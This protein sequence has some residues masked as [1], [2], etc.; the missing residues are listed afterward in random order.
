MYFMDEAIQGQAAATT[1]DRVEQGIDQSASAV[2]E[3]ACGS[4]AAPITRSRDSA[5]RRRGEILRWLQHDARVRVS[6]LCTHYNVSEVCIRR[7]LSILEARGLLQRYHGGARATI[8]AG[9]VMPMDA[10]MMQNVDPKRAIGQT[11]ATLVK[12]GNVIM[13]DAGSTVL[14]VARHIPQQIC[15]DGNL[16]VVTRSLTVASVF[17]QRPNVRLIVLG[18]LYS[19]KDDAFYGPQVEAAL[20]NIHVDMVFLGIDG[21]SLEHGVTTDNVTEANLCPAIVNTAKHVVGVTDASKIGLAQLQ[22]CLPL[23]RF[24]TLV[25]DEA[26]PQAFIDAVRAQNIDVMLS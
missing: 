3:T 25:T 2:L 5:E 22:A 21:I 24:H 16:T 18:G 10:R 1:P 15:D 19:H 4:S 11:A 12:N 20:Q 7:D 14:E 6:D 8:L 17:R 23:S 13:L 9:H 26:A